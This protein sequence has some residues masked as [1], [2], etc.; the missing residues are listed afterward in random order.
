VRSASLSGI[1]GVDTATAFF[2]KTSTVREGYEQI[3]GNLWFA[4]PDTLADDRGAL[5]SVDELKLRLTQLRGVFEYVLIDTPGTSVSGNAAILGRVADA[6][7]LVIEANRTRRLTARKAKEN[8]DAA[9][10]RLLGT[11]LY[12][13]VFPIPDQLYRRL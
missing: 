8:L 10:V 5:P 12:N 4:G 9:G 7:I 1:I 13:R 6:A 2:D 3:G 11:V